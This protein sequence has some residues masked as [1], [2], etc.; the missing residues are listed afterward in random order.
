[1]NNDVSRDQSAN[2][3]PLCVPFINGNESKYLQ[4][5]LETNW[6]SSAGPFVSRFEKMFSEYI[7]T[8]DAVATVNG[9]A[10][11]HTALL[12]AGIRADQ[13]VL[14][15][16]M[17][18]IAPIN[19]I[20]YVGAWPVFVDAEPE[21]WQMDIHRLR[22]F[23][24]NGCR[25]D[26]GTVINKTTGRQVKAILPVH[27]LG[28]P[29]D[30]DA[31]IELAHQYD[32]VVIEDATE[33]LGSKYKDVMVGHLG[34]VACFSFNGNKL[35]TTGGGGMLVTDNQVWADKARYLTTQAKDDPIEYIHNNI[36]YNYRL[37]NVNAAIGCAQ[38]ESV[39]HYI[40]HKREIA[41][42]YIQ[43]FQSVLGITAMQEAPWAYS[44]FWMFTIMIRADVLGLGSRDLLRGLAAYNIETRP[45]WQPNHMSPA[46]SGCQVLG[47]NVAEKLYSESL[48]L[49]CSVGLS[50]NDQLQILKTV[51]SILR[52]R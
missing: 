44:S 46:Y 20:R 27:I 14:V 26:N 21:Y 34:D 40:E 39:H 18:F 29:C 48:S 35:I 9:T 52:I 41:R 13:E 5:C 12:V 7:G 24:E 37:S 43:G 25:Y 15:S 11:L 8:S 36:G 45:L 16:T 31:I 30:M 23:L 17:T 42:T 47:G 10:A 33:S 3:I 19:A 22:D 4:E 1:M 51:E 28:H 49:P 50:K 32:L 2:S 6:L 38:L